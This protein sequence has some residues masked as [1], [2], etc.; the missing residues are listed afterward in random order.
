MAKAKIS[1]PDI[2]SK[3]LLYFFAISLWESHVNYPKHLWW[4]AWAGNF[5][6][7]PW[8]GLTAV[9]TGC[10]LMCGQS[11]PWLGSELQSCRLVLLTLLARD[12]LALPETT[13]P[14][15]H[16]LQSGA[17]SRSVSGHVALWPV[18]KAL[19]QQRAE[20]RQGQGEENCT[21]RGSGSCLLAG[22]ERESLLLEY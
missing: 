6:N 10:H 3:T 9:R 13:D 12:L 17:S 14:W 11:H 15:S 19:S 7:H 4:N 18:T 2:L 5:L 1:R 21:G 8:Q 22:L 16:L 20:G